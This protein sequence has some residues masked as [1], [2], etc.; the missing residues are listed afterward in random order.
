MGI[1]LRTRLAPIRLKPRVGIAFCEID[2]R[3]AVTTKIKFRKLN[4]FL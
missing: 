1:L 3:F 2:A 4:S